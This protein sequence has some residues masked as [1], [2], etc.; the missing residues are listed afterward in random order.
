M[1]KIWII[2]GL[3]FVLFAN[4]F[5][6]PKVIPIINEEF[7][8]C[9]DPEEN[10][11][12]FDLSQLEFI[13]ET[14]TNVFMNGSW[15]FLKEVKSPWVSTVFAERYERGQWNVEK[16]HKRIPDF[17]DSI[18]SDQ[19]PWYHVT[20]HFEPKNCPFPAGVSS[21]ILLSSFKWRIKT[22]FFYID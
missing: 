1:E 13:A 22:Q 2:K 21:T 16:L 9:I 20:K 11:G 8:S 17:C 10:A 5:C 3:V 6:H 12:K 19:E 18:Q 15:N 14:D 4:K 7:E